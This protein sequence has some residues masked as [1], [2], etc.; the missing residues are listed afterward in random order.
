MLLL[1]DGELQPVWNGKKYA[2]VSLTDQEL[3]KQVAVKTDYTV[4]EQ[5][6]LLMVY[7]EM[8]NDPNPYGTTFI[9]SDGCSCKIEE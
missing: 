8:Q 4:G 1:K 3:R 5:H 2:S 6:D 7:S 9:Y